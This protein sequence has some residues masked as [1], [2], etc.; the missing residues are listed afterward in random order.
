METSIYLILIL[1]IFVIDVLLAPVFFS[2]NKDETELPKSPGLSGWWRSALVSDM[3]DDQG[4]IKGPGVYVKSFGFLAGKVLGMVLLVWYYFKT[5]SGEM[6]PRI[7]NMVNAGIIVILSLK[8]IAYAGWFDDKQCANAYVSSLKSDKIEDIV[9]KI[10]YVIFGLLVALLVRDNPLR[11]SQFSVFCLMILPI[12]FYGI[13]WVVSRL[14][15]LGC[16]KGETF[17]KECAISPAT[18]YKE[19]ALGSSKESTTMSQSLDR[20]KRIAMLGVVLFFSYIFIMKRVKPSQRNTPITLIYGMIWV[21]YGIPLL[22]SMV[23]TVDIERKEIQTMTNTIM[24]DGEEQ[25]RD[26]G[27]LRCIINKYGGISGYFLLLCVQLVI[28][29]PKL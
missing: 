29:S 28:L 7:V 3:A 16:E 19:F 1:C 13:H 9:F 24:Q 6:G 5:T 8:Y 15:Y 11:S 10:V 27:Q 22:L 12:I 4:N 18:F 2:K 26:Y 23:M 25:T 17:S 20:Y 21:L 14:M